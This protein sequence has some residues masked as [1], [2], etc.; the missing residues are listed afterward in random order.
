MLL[1]FELLFDGDLDDA[2]RE[3]RPD[4]SMAAHIACGPCS[5]TVDSDAMDMQGDRTNGCI[6]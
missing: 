1:A 5:G 4:I 2:M 6:S 3:S